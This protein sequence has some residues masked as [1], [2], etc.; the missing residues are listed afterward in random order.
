MAQSLSLER[1]PGC[2]QALFNYTGV[3]AAVVPVGIGASFDYAGVAD[4]LREEVGL[5][6]RDGHCPSIDSQMVDDRKE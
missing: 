6:A 1:V 4:T 2:E 5:M 3:G